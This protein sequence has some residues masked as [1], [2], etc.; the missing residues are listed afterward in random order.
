MGSHVKILL[1]KQA[2]TDIT[3]P[4][5][6]LFFNN[7]QLEIKAKHQFPLTGPQKTMGCLGLLFPCYGP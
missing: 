5:T 6:S 3:N 4:P 1:A 7:V 2:M